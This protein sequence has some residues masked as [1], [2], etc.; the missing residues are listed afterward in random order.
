MSRTADGFL[1]GTHMD[2]KTLHRIVTHLQEEWRRINQVIWELEKLAA[3]KA[4][5]GR[6]P[7]FS[8]LPLPKNRKKE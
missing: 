1:D 5:R 7:K 3:G 8:T 6:P 2:P 4:R